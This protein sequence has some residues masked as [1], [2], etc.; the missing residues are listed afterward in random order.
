M[1]R[2][3]RQGCHQRHQ[4][5]E[6]PL[7]LTRDRLRP[8]IP[9]LQRVQRRHRLARR[10][11]D[12][13]P[14]HRQQLQHE[15]RRREGHLHLQPRILRRAGHH[16]R[17]GPRPPLH[18]DEDKLQVL[19]PPARAH[20]LRLHQ[21]QEGRQLRLQRALRSPGAHAEH[22]PL[23]DRPGHGREHRR[24]L[25]PGEQLPGQLQIRRTVQSRGDGQRRIQQ[26]HLA[27]G[28]AHHL[29]RLRLPLRP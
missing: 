19:R 4:R 18:V 11:E 22:E 25:H 13:R 3:Q 17:H 16:A 14:H 21:H 5:D 10:R 8:Q 20:R 9:L 28:E 23:L 6:P 7:Q 2:R 15:G 1:E 26:D 12:Q 29:R 24:V 27:R